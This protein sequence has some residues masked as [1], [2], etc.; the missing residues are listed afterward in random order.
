MTR[1]GGPLA[2]L[3]LHFVWIADCSGSMAA[4]GKMA[5]LN[6]AAREAVP[7][8]RK[9]AQEN[10]NASVLV[11]VLTFSTGASWVVA[12][13]TPVKYFQWPELS[14]IT[15]G[16]TD[17]GSALALL[18]RE[19]RAD[20]MPA[21]ALPPVLVLLTD[22]LP[23]DAFAAGL[24][25]LLDEPWGARSVRIA[26]GIGRDLD[27]DTLRR[28]INDPDIPPLKAGN[29]EQLVRYV[30]WASSHVLNAA[31]SRLA[32]GAEHGIRPP[33]VSRSIHAGVTW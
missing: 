4:Q 12:E 25:A 3:P 15:G 33:A 14:A 32:S 23:T 8:M 21:R 2:A 30:Q 17:L 5:S 26:V 20:T 7:H 22:G 9:V 19:M 13:P 1:P 16:L 6:H 24:D 27:V 31:S 11:R 18:A 29:A 10:P 28:F